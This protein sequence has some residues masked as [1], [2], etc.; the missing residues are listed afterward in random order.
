MFAELFSWTRNSHS[1]RKARRASQRYTQRLTRQNHMAIES[2]EPRQVLSVSI[3]G[4]VWMD[5]NGDGVRDASESASADGFRVYAFP[6]TAPGASVAGFATITQGQYS[7][8]NLPAGDY[9][10]SLGNE[11]LDPVFPFRY[12]PW[13]RAANESFDNDVNPATG[14]SSV[15]TLADGQSTSIDAGVWQPAVIQGRATFT[16]TINGEDHTI[17]I[18]GVKFTLYTAAG[19]ERAEFTTESNG[20]YAIGNVPEGDYYLTMTAIGDVTIAASTGQQVF[21]PLTRRTATFHVTGGSQTNAA[22]TLTTD[23]PIT[24]GGRVWHDFNANGVQD[25]GEPGI[26]NRTIYVAS[27]ENEAPTATTDAEGNYRFEGLPP[28]R[29]HFELG[30]Y[31]FSPYVDNF[32]ALSPPRQSNV[33]SQHDSD[34]QP[35]SGE[36]PDF[37]AIPGEDLLHFDAGMFYRG[38]VVGTVWD[39]VNGDGARGAAEQPMTAATVRL[40]REDGSLVATTRTSTSGEYSFRNQLPRTYI[41]EFARPEGTA[42]TSGANFAT[43]RTSPF[44]LASNTTQTQNAGIRGTSG[45]TQVV[46]SAFNDA[47]GDGIRQAGE[48]PV[49]GINIELLRPDGAFVAATTTNV[50]GDYTFANVVPGGYILRFTPAA[51]T[52]SPMNSG[53]SDATDSDVNRGSGLTAPFPIF[54]GQR[55]T[56][57]D[58]GIYTGAMSS[59]VLGS[60]RVTEVGF[61]GHANSEFVEVRNIG[62]QPIDLAGVQFTKGIKYQFN[63]GLKTLFP[64]EYGV[65]VG[66]YQ[67]LASR[68][69]VNQIN[70]LG[71]YSGDINREERLTLLDASGQTVHS[72]RYDDDWFVL[73]DRE[74]MPWTLSVIDDTIDAALWEQRSTWRPSSNLAGSPGRPDPGTAPLPGSILINEVLTKSDDGFNDLVELHNTTDVDINIGGWYL[75]DSRS[76]VSPLIYLTRYRLPGGTVVPA[77]G[78]LVLSREDDFGVFGLSSFGETLHLVAGDEYGAMAGYAESISFGATEPGVSFGRFENSAGKVDMVPQQH[79]TFG[80]ANSAPRIGPVV[81]SEV[82][83]N[84]ADGVDF[85]EIV[86]ISPTP[87]DLGSPTANWQLTGGVN[88]NFAQG[89][90]L[91]PGARA[92]ISNVSPTQFRLQHNLGLEVIVAGPWFGD[93]DNGGGTVELVLNDDEV[94]RRDGQEQV[95]QFRIDRIDYDDSAPWPSEADGGGA[96]LERISFNVYGN[97]ISNW[98]ASETPGGTPGR[99]NDTPLPG[100]IDGSGTVTTTDIDMLTT[101]VQLGTFDSHYDLDDSGTVDMND[102]SFLITTLLGISFGDTNLDGRAGLADLMTVQRNLGKAGGWGQGDFDGNGIVTRADLAALLGGFGAGA[103]TLAAPQAVVVSAAPTPADP[104]RAVAPA[105]PRDA[106]R[107]DAALTTESIAHRPVGRDALTAARRV[108]TATPQA[109]DSAIE[110]STSSGEET[111]RIRRRQRVAGG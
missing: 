34:F 1:A 30:G 55:E 98:M 105:A 16:G 60:L 56:S 59:D 73:M 99:A 110:A 88:F 29:Y 22:V 27:R 64:G 7:I 51:G 97:H 8:T 2:L 68:T 36:S 35:T 20:Y 67:L 23:S 42:I 32:E 9:V 100:D 6:A 107:V 63:S 62:T 78:Y 17:G 12:S 102:R 61:V 111:L 104:R 81:I 54:S 106:A 50:G 5:T 38:Q 79:T 74:T 95:K 65:I 24:A 52:F 96:S 33:D 89:T 90:V 57:Q 93:L 41:V 77:N 21:D 13:N 91:Q 48:A 69:D 19:A 47:N 3:A 40:L 45:A 84:G 101:M 53:E 10:V 46:G 94:Q 109:V 44:V 86:N 80:G 83:Y 15:V 25:S 28:A 82:M 58:V 4:S 31:S 70:V 71:L 72:F 66:D 108:R 14:F 92:V 76:E 18:S 26:P 37:L 39:D 85:V 11:F 43:G 103:T 75:G 87:V 49:S